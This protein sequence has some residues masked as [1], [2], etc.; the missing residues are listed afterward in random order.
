MSDFELDDLARKMSLVTP[1]RKVKLLTDEYGQTKKNKQTPEG[2]DF[3]WISDHYVNWSLESLTV[4]GEEN[5]NLST[6]KEV[7]IRVTKNP[8]L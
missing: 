7:A 6:Q 5:S 3:L 8:H 2:Q 4:F 1:K